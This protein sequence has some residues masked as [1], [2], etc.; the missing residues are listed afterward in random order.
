MSF[1]L[2][3]KSFGLTN[4]RATSMDLMNSVFKHYLDLLVIV[5]IDD[6]LINSRN[7]EEHAS[8][9]RIF[10]QTLKDRQLFSKFSKCEF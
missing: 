10:L 2:T 8:H 4:N 3:N 1:G 6:I 7:E 9:L 5:F